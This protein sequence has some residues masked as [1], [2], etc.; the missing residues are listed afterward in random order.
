MAYDSTRQRIVLFGGGGWGR[1]ESFND[2]WE[3]NGASWV[4]IDAYGP[5][6]RIGAC[7]FY[8]KTLQAMIL[9]GGYNT[10]TLGD[11][12]KYDNGTTCSNTTYARM[13]SYIKFSTRA[14]KD[15]ASMRTCINNAF[16]NALQAGPDKVILNV[17]DCE[18]VEIDGD[19]IV[20][21]AS[22]TRFLAVSSTYKLKIDC[23]EGWLYLS[24]KNVDLDDCDTNPVKFCVT[25]VKAG[26]EDL[27]LCAQEEFD[28]QRDRKGILKK[29]FL[30]VDEFCSP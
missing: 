6:S 9:Y 15:T 22:K 11:T 4:Q 3:W 25:I 27:C 28:E 1:A 17:N 5:A 26:E 19:E 13:L 30:V 2:T 21:N 7:L 10:S 16:C 18:E 29:L 23:T 12:W 14:L 8:D 20:S 24:L